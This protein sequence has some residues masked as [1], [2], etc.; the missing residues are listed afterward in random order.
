M[1][2]DGTARALCLFFF[3][4]LTWPF[5]GLADVAESVFGFPSLLLYI[6]GGWAL[7]VAALAAVSR[8]VRD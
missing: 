1:R 8:K 2:A 7:L 5:L 6:F 4:A 3:L